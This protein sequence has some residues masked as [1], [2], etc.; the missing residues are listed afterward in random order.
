MYVET[1]QGQYGLVLRIVQAERTGAVY[2]LGGQPGTP[3][4]DG[5]RLTAESRQQY[6]ELE[7]IGFQCGWNLIIKAVQ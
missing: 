6:R 1:R 7:R 5:S 3:A 4:R 2:R